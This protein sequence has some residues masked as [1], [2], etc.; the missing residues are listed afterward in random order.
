VCGFT[1]RSA[2]RL[3]S[4]SAR[5]CADQRREQH[6]FNP[7]IVLILVISVAANALLGAWGRRI[8]AR[9]GVR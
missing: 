7:L 5:L 6:A 9:R 8:L 1:F 2:Q 3:R 4:R